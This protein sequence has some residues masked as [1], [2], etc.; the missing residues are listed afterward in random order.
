MQPRQKFVVLTLHADEKNWTWDEGIDSLEELMH[1]R[2]NK[3]KCPKFDSFGVDC[4]NQN[5]IR[6]RAVLSAPIGTAQLIQQLKHAYS[7]DLRRIS[8]HHHN[9]H[10]KTRHGGVAVQVIK[11]ELVD[12]SRNHNKFWHIYQKGREWWTQYGRYREQKPRDAHGAQSKVKT[13][14]TPEVA[15]KQITKLIQQKLGKGYTYAH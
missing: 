4:V 7:R 2:W 10:H 3:N 6:V 13:E 1:D 12:T 11:L 14:P 8:I 5:T 9:K 15:Q